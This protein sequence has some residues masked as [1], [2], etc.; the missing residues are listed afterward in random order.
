MFEK[1]C[2]ELENRIA[3]LTQEIERLNNVLRSRLEEISQLENAYK[4][5]R[6]YEVR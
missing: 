2:V 3:L 6:L 4:E 1:R 5:S